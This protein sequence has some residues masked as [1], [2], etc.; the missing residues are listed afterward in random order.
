MNSL[1]MNRYRKVEPLNSNENCDFNYDVVSTIDVENSVWKIL[2]F[3]QQLR[4]LRGKL[5][6]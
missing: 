1:S 4:F 2:N 6:I 5:T 3:H